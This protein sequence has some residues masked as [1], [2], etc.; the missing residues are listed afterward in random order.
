MILISIVVR[1]FLN[2]S[3]SDTYMIYPA[4]ETFSFLVI[5]K[6]FF[7]LR[8]MPYLFSIVVCCIFLNHLCSGNDIETP[9]D[10]HVYHGMKMTLDANSTGSLFGFSLALNKDTLFV[11]APRYDNRNGGGFYCN[12]K[13]CTQE[14]SCS[15]ISNL[16]G[17]GK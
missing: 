14:C 9:I 5:R 8:I 6:R 4:Y 7:K 10:I 15:A 13:N 16:N 2:V 12:L 3:A 1:H 17:K 11:G